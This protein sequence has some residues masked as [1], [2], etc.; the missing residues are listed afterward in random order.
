MTKTDNER[1]L[2]DGDCRKCRRRGYCSKPCTMN[3]RRCA[4][5]L[6]L[7]LLQR[8]FGMADTDDRGRE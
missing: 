4:V 1:W 7:A 5:E 3:K 8:M 2:S 6:R